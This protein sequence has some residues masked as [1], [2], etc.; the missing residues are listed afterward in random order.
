LTHEFFNG[1]YGCIGF[2]KKG[3]A[4]NGTP[5]QT[6]PQEFEHI[7]QSLLGTDFI[8]IH[9]LDSTFPVVEVSSH[10]VV[11]SITILRD[12]KKAAFQQLV[13]LT[14][15]DEPQEEKR[16][17]VVYNLLSHKENKRLMVVVRVAENQ[18]VP[19]LTGVFVNANWYEREA[20]DLFGVSFD[21]HPDM[22]RIL[23]DY[24][25][26]GHPLRKDFPLSGYTQVYFD[27]SSGK[28]ALEPV[29]LDQPYRDFDFQSPWEGLIHQNKIPAEEAP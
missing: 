2:T 26:E 4:V 25:F 10:S 23:T 1:Y 15:V 20:F 7:L 29:H 27:K 19:T 6:S 3:L 28:V 12:H 18:A 9:Y 13:D 8:G 22:R 11:R 5:S 14:V 21:G 24:H 17:R 16:F